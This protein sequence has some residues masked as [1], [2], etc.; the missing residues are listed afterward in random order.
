MAGEA[1]VSFT[2]NATDD[3]S[4][5][6]TPAGHA[7]ANVTIAV[8]GREKKGDAWVDGAAAFYRVAVWRDAA[9]NLANSIT[10]GDR[11]SVVGRLKPREFE[12]NGVNRISLEV[13]ADS[14][15]LDVR[16]TTAHFAERTQ[17]SGPPATPAA[18]LDAETQ[19]RSARPSQPAADPWATPAA[20]AETPW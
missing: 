15:A 16:F 11:V 20:K 3:V 18:R 8:T 19:R 6:Y 14:V 1:L 9:E 12:Q 13:D 4:L 17:R 10:K 5:K 7:V 2:G